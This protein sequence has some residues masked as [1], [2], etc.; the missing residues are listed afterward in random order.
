MRYNAFHEPRPR[1]SAEMVEALEER[2]ADPEDCEATIERGDD[3]GDFAGWTAEV[4]N[5]D[6]DEVFATLGYGED[7]AG[8]EADLKAA[9]IYQL[10]YL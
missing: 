8:L 1:G 5:E 2:D 9:G 6:G 10:H 4:R 3:Q 7:K